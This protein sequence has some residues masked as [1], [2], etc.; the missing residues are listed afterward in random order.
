MA[1]VWEG[2]GADEVLLVLDVDFIELKDDDEVLL[3]VLCVLDALVG[4]ETPLL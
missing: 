4:E 3:W 2:V 1:S